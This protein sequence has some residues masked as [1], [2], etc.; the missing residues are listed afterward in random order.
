[1][2]VRFDFSELGYYFDHFLSFNK[3]HTDAQMITVA[4]CPGNSIPYCC[5]TELECV[6]FLVC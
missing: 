5:E 4:R 1:M 2:S 3:F 6:F